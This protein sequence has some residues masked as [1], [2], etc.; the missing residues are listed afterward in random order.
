M[1]EEEE[2][3]EGGWEREVVPGP[4]LVIPGEVEPPPRKTGGVMPTRVAWILHVRTSISDHTV[5]D[6]ENNKT[7]LIK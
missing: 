3:E 1:R 7:Y 5:Q 6:L 2:E 4:P